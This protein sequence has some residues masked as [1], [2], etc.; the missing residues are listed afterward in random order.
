VKYTDSFHLPVTKQMDG[1]DSCAIAGTVETLGSPDE[2][3]TFSMAQFLVYSATGDKY[4]ARHP[5]TTKWYGR[6]N[7]FSRD[8]LIPLLCTFVMWSDLWKP[9]RKQV[10]KLHLK[11]CLL[12]AWNSI[13][14]FVYD[15]PEEHIKM[16]TPDVPYNRKWKM[17]DITGPE[18][19]GLWI[20]ANRVWPLYPLLFLFDLE[21]LIGSLLWR[22]KESN[23]SRNHLLV[24][25][26]TNSVYPTLVSRAALKLVN[27]Q[28]LI[29]K[30]KIHCLSSQ[31][32]DTFTDFEKAF[33]EKGWV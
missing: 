26:V 8:Q 6:P 9:F 31:E 33:K 23:I 20:R 4:L 12:F 30:W 22:N 16:S 13:K 5:D 11:R 21:T 27:I 10:F 3:P 25:Y 29:D 19:W 15:S 2:K 32:Y 17:P 1:G 24:L 14:N 7:R 18:I 28:N